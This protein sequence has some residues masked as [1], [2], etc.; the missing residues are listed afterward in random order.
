MCQNDCIGQARCCV[1][2]CHRLFFEK[3]CGKNVGQT[4]RTGL[5]EGVHH[6]SM[7]YQ[8]E[9]GLIVWGTCCVQLL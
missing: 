6:S 1:R 3:T 5:R 9:L 7:R 2:N 4:V 8:Q